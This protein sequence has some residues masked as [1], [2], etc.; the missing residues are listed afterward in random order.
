MTT[1]ISYNFWN[2]VCLLPLLFG[3]FINSLNWITTLLIP[4]FVNLRKSPSF[5]APKFFPGRRKWQPTSVF[6]PGES[7]G[8]RSLEDYSPLGL[9]ELYMTGWQVFSCGGGDA[10]CST[11]C[12]YVQLCLTLCDRMDCSLPGSSIHG[13]LQARI[14]E[15]VSISFSRWSF[16][17]S[18]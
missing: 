12:S 7:H 3:I 17:H 10:F 13:N 15:W 5:C 18:E 9:K 16:Q 14:L 4:I 8:Q 2:S 11:S 6:F 1:F